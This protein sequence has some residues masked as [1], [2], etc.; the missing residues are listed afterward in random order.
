M[1]DT[2]SESASKTDDQ[3]LTGDEAKTIPAS[4]E[5]AKTDETG[6]ATLKDKPPSSAGTDG[7]AAAGQTRDPVADTSAPG[8]TFAHERKNLKNGEQL[9]H[10]SELSAAISKAESLLRDASERGVEVKDE[11]ISSITQASVMFGSGTWGEGDETSF[12]KSYRD[13]CATMS[14]VAWVNKNSK[15]MAGIFS[16]VGLL[17]LV[18][19]VYIRVIWVYNTSAQIKLISE[20]Y[21]RM[22]ATP[23]V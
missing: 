11:T 6:S 8:A 22:S 18:M 14:L 23:G 3:L 12:W 4:E 9:A 16:V 1:S 5:S 10:T 20:E 2:G 13:I 19:L 17:V 21:D 7:S 15:I